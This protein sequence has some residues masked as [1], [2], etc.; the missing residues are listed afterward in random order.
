MCLLAYTAVITPVEVA[1][2]A[3]EING[4]FLLN[5]AIDVCFLAVMRPTRARCLARVVYCSV[6]MCMTVT[7]PWVLLCRTWS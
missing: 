3:P 2:T 5:R 7:Q 6:R 1:F 4:L